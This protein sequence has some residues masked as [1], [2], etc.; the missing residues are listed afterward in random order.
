MK[1]EITQKYVEFQ[2]LNQQIQQA[3]QQMQMLSQQT[4]ELKTLSK[5]LS[6]LS[7]IESGSE[8]YNNLGV[9]VNIKSTVQ[10]LKHLLVNVGAGILVQKTPKETIII[11]NKQVTELEKFITN[12]ETNLHSSI[13]KAEQLKQEIEKEQQKKK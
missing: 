1:Q 11:V 9:G 6:G 4:M 12:L 13:A 2:L 5:N 10:D 7:S 3:Q 8:M